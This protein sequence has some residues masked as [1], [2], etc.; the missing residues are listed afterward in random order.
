MTEIRRTLFILLAAAVALPAVDP[1]DLSGSWMLDVKHSK[2][3]RKARPNK[4][5]LQIEHTEPKLKYSGTVVDAKDVESTFSFDGAIDGKAYPLQDG[6]GN[7]MVT[8]K[9][10][11]PTTITS[12]ITSADGKTE[13]TA[14]TTMSKDG[15]SI[16]RK[17]T[18]KGPEGTQT[19]TE[20]YQKTS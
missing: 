8:F 14:V 19:W 1:Y 12:T 7:Q 17:M 2:W 10:L 11:S 6:G 5:T 15:K 13:E 4:V 18:L 20:V 16:V 9:R 3:N